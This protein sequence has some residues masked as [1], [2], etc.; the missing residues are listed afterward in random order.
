MTPKSGQ[1]WDFQAKKSRIVG[2]T[3][4]K[5]GESKIWEPYCGPSPINSHYCAP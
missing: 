4:K 1:D 5:G 2:L 3:G